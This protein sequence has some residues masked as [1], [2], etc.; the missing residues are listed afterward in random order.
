MGKVFVKGPVESPNDLLAKQTAA[1][2]PSMS[3]N[4]RRR[5]AD[6]GRTVRDEL[7]EL[8]AAYGPAAANYAATR[9]IAGGGRELARSVGKFANNE[10]QNFGQFA[11]AGINPIIALLGRAPQTPEEQEYA[12]QL[13]REQIAQQRQEELAPEKQEAALRQFGIMGMNETDVKNLYPFMSAEEALNQEMMAR[14]T[15][16]RRERVAALR[17]E[18]E[19]TQAQENRDKQ[20]MVTT[21]DAFAGLPENLKQFRER[22][23]QGDVLDQFMG[24]DDIATERLLESLDNYEPP[25]LGGVSGMAVPLPIDATPL[26]KV[27]PP[28]DE[29]TL[30]RIEANAQNISPPQANAP[31]PEPPADGAKAHIAE[32][33]A[34]AHNHNKELGMNQTNESTMRALEQQNNMQSQKKEEEGPEP[35]AMPPPDAGPFG[36]SGNKALDNLGREQGR[37]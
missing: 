2:A 8:A 14:G 10:I 22:T 5:G 6:F 34:A 29:E 17:G 27:P 1:V 21:S 23:Q 19:T 11:A 28:T 26:P 32:V 4:I 13:L 16:A 37:N 33:E 31:P 24:N 18:G 3:Q 35:L 36:F 9:D 15:V 7:K 20:T 25:K 30:K 12:R